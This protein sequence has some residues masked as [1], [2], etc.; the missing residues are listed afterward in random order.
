MSQPGA[1]RWTGLSFI[2]ALGLAAAALTA[3]GTGERGID[4]A[5]F[6]TARLGFLLFWPAYTGSALVSLFGP[7]FQRLR[8]HAREFGLAFA[9]VL[10]VHLGLVGWLC[11]IG[12]APPVATFVLF[13][14]AAL[15]VYLLALFS[16]GGLQQRL[17]AKG[18]WVL[19]NIGMNYV[20]YVFAVDFFARPLAGGIRHAVFYWPF[21]ALIT[22]GPALR[23][24]AAAQRIAYGWKG[25]LRGTG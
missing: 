3:A 15:W 8:R 24:A 1:A 22:V 19:R 6:A 7:R 10:L 14:I 5:L 23:L 20:A 2:A 21:A 17:G 13:G 12:A 16:I 9:T 18:W 25:A 4:L 11:L